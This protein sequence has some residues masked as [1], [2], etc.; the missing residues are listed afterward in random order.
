M[1]KK[2]IAEESIQG[3]S[4]SIATLFNGALGGAMESISAFASS[5]GS[6]VGTAGVIT[7][8]TAGTV[9]LTEKIAGLTETMQGGNGILTQTGGY[10]HD[11]VG[12]MENAHSITRDQAR[13]FG[14][15]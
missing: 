14:N 13:N 11:Y 12:A 5:L 15:S 9:V 7:A 1:G 8:V 2:L 3:L 6:L 4:G 10:L